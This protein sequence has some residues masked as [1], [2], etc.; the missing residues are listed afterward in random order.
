MVYCSQQHKRQ[1]CSQRIL[2]EVAMALF[3]WCLCCSIIS[4]QKS[5]R[6]STQGID[7][8]PPLLSLARF[9]LSHQPPA[10]AT[11]WFVC[12]TLQSILQK[13]LGPLVDKASADAYC[14]GDMGNWYAISQ[15]Q[16]DST[17]SGTPSTH[18]CGTL[19]RHQRLAFF[20]CE[21][22]REGCVTAMR[23]R[24][25]STPGLCCHRTASDG[26]CTPASIAITGWISHPVSRQLFP[27]RVFCV[28]TCQ[29]SRW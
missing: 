13:T 15:L 22:N 3:H 10:C 23:H 8:S 19:P 18:S 26:G 1:Q 17:A 21:L 28:S 25:P 2:V 11:A 20:S 24:V 4:K 5:P 16:N 7:F 12:Q 29:L 14:L 27:S 6:S 9:S